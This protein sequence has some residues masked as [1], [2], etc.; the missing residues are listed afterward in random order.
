MPL[1][2]SPVSAADPTTSSVPFGVQLP[3]GSRQL[4]VTAEVGPTATARVG[5]TPGVD[6]RVAAYQLSIGRRLEAWRAGIEARMPTGELAVPDALGRPPAE[7]SARAAWAH[8]V[9]VVALARA[10]RR[11]GTPREEA[12][13]VES[14]RAAWARIQARRLGGLV[15]AEAGLQR[16][17]R[18][19][20]PSASRSATPRLGPQGGGGGG[21]GGG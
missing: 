14:L 20:G 15:G 11:E 12:E 17:S 16:R 8:A 3:H 5:P 19:S 1:G 4:G 6:P 10:V 2:P 9:S 21:V 13:R 7:A 18:S